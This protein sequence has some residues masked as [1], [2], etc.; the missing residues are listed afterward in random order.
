MRARH[1][2]MREWVGAGLIGEDQALAIDAYEEARKAGRFGRGLVGLSLF[3]ILVGILSIIASNWHAIPGG[4]KIG[5]HALLNLGIGAAVFY[6][7]KRGM[8]LLR[9]GATLVFFG[10]TLT[11]I[12]LIGQVYQ[13]D[14]TI[15]DALI[16]W[17][18]IT[19]PFFLV[20]GNGYM[21][22]VPWM[23]AFLCTLVFAL[24]EYIGDL[25]RIAH[26]IVLF[27]F[28]ALLPLALMAAGT[29]RHVR[30]RRTALAMIAI[31]A[32]LTLSCAFATTA[33]ILMV[34][35]PVHVDWPDPLHMLAITAA[36]LGLLFA[37]AFFHGFYSDDI[38]MRSGALFAAM[39]L[40]II[41]LPFV[42]AV[43]LGVAAALLFIG[44]WVFIG[45]LGE[46]TMQMRLVSIAI[47]VIAVRVF[48]IYVEVFGSLLST[49]FGLI[50]GGLVMLLLLYLARR[51]NAHMRAKAVPA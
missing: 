9:E 51:I 19:L 49:G 41:T 2:K 44:Y 22:A 18:V 7:Q 33:L 46:R 12:V 39:G 50:S 30:A 35:M 36:G 1:K 13:I 15:A 14:G 24:G 28:V 11:L 29:S 10:L 40:V 5:V 21:T 17:M 48:F 34:D 42:G 32:G 47:T 6:A 16:F 43:D 4:V 3:A 37:H 25:G 23:I 45:W 26:D 8:A 20:A 27:G 38:T 31:R